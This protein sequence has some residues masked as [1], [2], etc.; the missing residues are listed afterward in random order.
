MNMFRDI[1]MFAFMG[2][3]AALWFG[4]PDTWQ[5]PAT[6]GPYAVEFITYASDGRPWSVILCAAMALALFMTRLRY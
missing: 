4:Q 6:L 2:L 1:F 5:W 3:G